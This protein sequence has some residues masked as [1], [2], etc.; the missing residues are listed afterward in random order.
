[1]AKAQVRQR[2]LVYVSIA[3]VF[4]SAAALIGYRASQGQ[5]TT[6]PPSNIFV[7]DRLLIPQS[8]GPAFFAINPIIG[9]AFKSSEKIIFAGADGSK[10]RQVI[11]DEKGDVFAIDSGS[12]VSK[13]KGDM[14]ANTKIINAQNEGDK[15]AA[16]GT[17]NDQPVTFTITP[18]RDTFEVRTESL[19]LQR[20]E[21][22]L[23]PPQDIVK[24]DD[25]VYSAEIAT[26]PDDVLARAEGIAE[27]IG[28]MITYKLP[29]NDFTQ[30]V[31]N[32]VE[33]IIALEETP[34]PK[35]P[36]SDLVVG[37]E[38]VAANTFIFKI[39][40]PAGRDVVV[41]AVQYVTELDQKAAEEQIAQG[42]FLWQETISNPTSQD[43]IADTSYVLEQSASVYG[44]VL[45]SVSGLT[46]IPPVYL[47]VPNGNI[48]DAVM[49]NLEQKTRE[50]SAAQTAAMK[51]VIARQ[52]FTLISQQLRAAQEQAKQAVDSTTEN[53][54]AIGKGG[55]ETDT[56]NAAPVVDLPSITNPT[57]RLFAIAA[58]A[59]TVLAVLFMTERTRKA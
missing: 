27:Q 55:G 57:A 2:T 18:Y 31:Y 36:P 23:Q 16:Q 37:T 52:A 56:I 45:A 19:S 53:P 29:A 22:K 46:N 44:H 49:T 17:V 35:E 28:E 34:V 38:Q 32:N 15:I 50:Y 30:A 21:I 42:N 5:V 26:G 25:N 33:A 6:L 14:P 24:I 7:L 54:N 3:I 41:T 4:L 1:M 39:L 51:E 11:I 8:S 20:N 58:L 9:F 40:V 10:S 13:L 48:N 43:I 47:P 12:Q 59:L